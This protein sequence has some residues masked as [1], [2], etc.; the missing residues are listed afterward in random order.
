[1]LGGADVSYEGFVHLFW[2][3]VREGERWLLAGLRVAYKID[4]FHARDIANPPQFDREELA[5][6]RAAY[7][8]MMINL[9]SAGLK[10]RDDLNGF[11]RPETVIALRHGEEK[12]LAKS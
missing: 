5:S 7:R 8:Y 9:Q 2:R 11:D 1:V 12:W 6:Y 3:A 4:M 10:V